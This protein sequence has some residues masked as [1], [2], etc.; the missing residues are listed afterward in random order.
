[1]RLL[2][3]FMFLSTI[4]FSDIGTHLLRWDDTATVEWELPMDETS[5]SENG[6]ENAEDH[7]E[8]DKLF[9]DSDFVALII[10]SENTLLPCTF[11]VLFH[12]SL[13]K[14]DIPPPDQFLG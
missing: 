10:S 6:E 14:I 2:Y 3:S 7:V 11:R 1:M 4:F 13:K 5:D 8:K 9:H 12:Q